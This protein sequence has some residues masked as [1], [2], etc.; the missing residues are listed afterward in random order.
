MN[1]LPL[2]GRCLRPLAPRLATWQLH[3]LLFLNPSTLSAKRLESTSQPQ[4]GRSAQP[5]PT[6]GAANRSSNASSRAW[7]PTRRVPRRPAAVGAREGTDQPICRA[8]GRARRPRVSA[9]RS[10]PGSARDRAHPGWARGPSSAL[11][12]QP[13]APGR[14]RKFPAQPPHR[15]QSSA[16]SGKDARRQQPNP[17]ARSARLAAPRRVGPELGAQ[18]V[19]QAPGPGSRWRLH[20]RRCT[21]P[22]GRG[23]PGGRAEPG[24]RGPAEP[25]RGE[26]ETRRH[27]P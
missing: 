9:P 7:P 27:P 16:R 12:T 14:A 21:G 6:R 4:I 20:A 2:A 25:P 1:A 13:S 11:R 18:P 8:P 23:G 15:L 26:E 22:E 10:E 5:D 3:P 19:V 24:E 17:P